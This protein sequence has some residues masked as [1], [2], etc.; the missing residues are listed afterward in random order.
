MGK[1]EGKERRGVVIGVGKCGR[2]GDDREW[3][4]RREKW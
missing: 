2:I 1:V 3:R 4:R